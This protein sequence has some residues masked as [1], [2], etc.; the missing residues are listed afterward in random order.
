ME[1]IWPKGNHSDYLKVTKISTGVQRCVHIRS[2]EIF[3]TA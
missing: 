1:K 2:Y 3:K